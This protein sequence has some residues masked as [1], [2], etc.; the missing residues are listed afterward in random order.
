MT[1]YGQHSKSFLFKFFATILGVLRCREVTWEC[2][3]ESVYVQ[4]YV[5]IEL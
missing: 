2:Q 5:I 1:I 3:T 4:N